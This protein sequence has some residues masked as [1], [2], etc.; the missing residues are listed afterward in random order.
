MT[1][2]ELMEFLLD[3]DSGEL[4]RE[5][6]AGFEAHLAECPDCVAYLRAYRRTIAL[7]KD[8]FGSPDDPQCAEM[9]EE[10]VQAILAARGRRA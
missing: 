7:E 5:E 4:S 1:C 9:P 2:R 10:L 3:Y 6:R 8:A